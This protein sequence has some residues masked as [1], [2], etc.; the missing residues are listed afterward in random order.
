MPSGGG[1]HRID[2]ASAMGKG[3]ASV[4]KGA[5]SV[6]NSVGKGAASAGGRAAAAGRHASAAGKSAAREQQQH[7]PPPSVGEAPEPLPQDLMT[8]ASELPVMQEIVMAPAG[9]MAANYKYIAYAWMRKRTVSFLAIVSVFLWLVGTVAWMPAADGYDRTHPG[10]ALWTAGNFIVD[11]GNMGA[12][13]F[14]F[15]SS[16]PPRLTPPAQPRS[17]RGRN[18]WSRW[19]SPSEAFSSTPS[20]SV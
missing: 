4:G 6:G 8:I 17:A 7:S 13:V 18:G 10:H 16:F 19:A 9:D 11:P 20:S 1:Y 2:M 5:A 14:L 12:C 3:A 15:F